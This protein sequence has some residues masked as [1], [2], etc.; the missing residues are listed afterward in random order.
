[1]RVYRNVDEAFPLYVRDH[2]KSVSASIRD[3]T[4][5]GAETDIAFKNQ[6]GTVLFSLDE[7]N[8]STMMD[9]RA[10][11]IAYSNDPCNNGEFFNR[12]IVRIR[13]GRNYLQELKMKIAGVITSLSAG[14]E[15]SGAGRI[16]HEVLTSLKLEPLAD[17]AAQ[18]IED[19]RDAAEL[20]AGNQA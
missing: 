16:L 15:A 12:E 18:E 10:A 1:V 8:S 4:G 9:F 14:G 20:L 11:Y 13:E 5:F 2:E 17:V 19:A 6:I 3:A 7:L